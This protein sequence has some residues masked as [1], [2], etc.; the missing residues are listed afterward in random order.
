MVLART[1]P[2]PPSELSTRFSDASDNSPEVLAVSP[3]VDPVLALSEYGPYLVGGIVTL[4]DAS[5][6]M[7]IAVH[8]GANALVPVVACRSFDTSSAQTFIRR[9]VLDGI[10]LV[11][12][13]SVACKRTCALRSWG[14]FGEP[15]AL[16]TS[17]SIRLSVRYF[18][19]DEPRCSL[20]VWA[21]E[22]P[23]SVMQHAVLL[24]GDSWVCFNKRYYRSLP[25][26]SSDH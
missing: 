23:T 3:G 16:Q 8:G 2:G 11:W 6:N 12:E 26:Q 4:D 22:V 9:D 7:E 5:L 17:T 25:P 21:G 14:G 19:A 10:L 24:G 18:R 15:A 20:A 1:C 13:E